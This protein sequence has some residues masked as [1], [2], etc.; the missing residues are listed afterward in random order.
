MTSVQVSCR[1]VAMGA[2]LAVSCVASGQSIVVDP[3]MTGAD[4]VVLL[5][6]S[7]QLIGPFLPMSASEV[8]GGGN[9]LVVGNTSNGVLEL[10][11]AGASLQL[12]GGRLWVGREA[13]SDGTLRL[14]NGATFVKT[15]SL[16]GNI[17]RDGTGRV[18]VW[19]GSSF[20]YSTV[21][22]LGLNSGSTGIVDI[23]ASTF[24]TTGLQIGN[25]GNATFTA[26]NLSTI[27]LSSTTGF[28]VG[29]GDVS[30][31]ETGLVATAI[32]DNST[33]T[34]AGGGVDL[35]VGQRAGI[36]GTLTL[37]NNAMA[38]FDAT[39]GHFIGE[40]SGSNGTL[41]IESGSDLTLG[42][43]LT[44]G[45]AA[46]STGAVTVDGMGS[47]LT[48][49]G[50][51]TSFLGDS[52]TGVLNISN[53]GSASFSQSLNLA[54]TGTMSSGTINI[55][56]AGSMLSTVN[57]L[58][59]GREGTGTLAASAGAFI[60]VGS[61]LN[62]GNTTTG[63]GTG[64]FTGTAV[65]ALNLT[66]GGNGMGI[67]TAQSGTS[68]TIGNVLNIGT[69]T[70]ATGSLTLDGS[71]L[72]A[73]GVAVIGG[74]GD[75]TLT[76]RNG[77]DVAIN[78]LP[79]S[80]VAETGVGSLNIESGSSLDVAGA[81]NV[82]EFAS[83]VGTINIGGTNSELIA[84]DGLNIGNRGMGTLTATDGA[85][86]EL[87]TRLNI[88]GSSTGDGMATMSGTTLIA[89]S[90]LVARTGT[91]E[92]TV[93]NGSTL[94]FGGGFSI[95]RDAGASGTMSITDTTVTTGT[96]GVS[97]GVAGTGT[98]HAA[99]SDITVVGGDLQIGSAN[100]G[101]MSL[102]NG[103]SL[104]ITNTGTSVVG[105]EAN[106]NTP[107]GDGTLTVAGG[108]MG[109]STFTSA[110]SLRVADGG[111]T[112]NV[113]ISGTGSS[114]TL[115]ERLFVGYD[116]DGTMTV[117]D[118]ATLNVN[119]PMDSSNV[120]FN[121]GS[122]ALNITNGGSAHFTPDLYVGRFADG[123]LNADNATISLGRR[124][125]ISDDD[126][127]SGEVTLS[128]SDLTAL[129]DMIVA[130]RGTGTLTMQSGS[131]AT[132]AGG[133]FVGMGANGMGTLA[134][135]ASSVATVNGEAEF[136]GDSTGTGN[137]T[138]DGAGSTLS[139]S[140]QVRF[141][142]DGSSTATIRNG[143][144][145]TSA[146]QITLGDD[147]GSSGDVAIETG[148][149]F[150]TTD[151]LRIGNEG[152][153]T[154]TVSG[155]SVQATDIIIASGLGSGELSIA[156]GGVIADNLT[157]GSGSSTFNF[158]S[159][160]LTL[161]ADQ[162][163]GATLLGF[164]NG[165]NAPAALVV[166]AD[167]AYSLLGT[168]N[169][170]SGTGQIDLNGG[171]LT[172]GDFTRSGSADIDFLSGTLT[173]QSDQTLDGA[174]LADFGLESGVLSDALG[175]QVLRIEGNADLATSLELDGGSLFAQTLSGLE[176]LTATRGNLE[177][178]QLNVT[179]QTEAFT[180]PDSFSNG[181]VS[182]SINAIDVASGSTLQGGASLEAPLNIQDGGTLRLTEGQTL[183]LTNS[184]VSTV[185]NS[186][187]IDLSG[188]PAL[189]GTGLRAELSSDGSITNS[190]GAEIDMGGF[191]SL[192]SGFSSITN[193]GT[194]DIRNAFALV[195]AQGGF[196]NNGLVRVDANSQVTITGDVTNTSLGT[197]S[198]LPGSSYVVIDN[199]FVN[200]G[201]VVD[202]GAGSTV[203]LFDGA[204]GTNLSFTGG[205]TVVFFG[206][207]LNPR[208]DDGEARSAGTSGFDVS[209]GGDVRFGV[210][211]NTVIELAGTLPGMFDRVHGTADVRLN[212][213]LTVDFADGFRLARNQEFLFFEIDGIREGTYRNLAEGA[214]VGT[215]NGLDVFV[216]YLGGDG[217]DIALYTLP[218]PGTLALG[219]LALPFARRR[220]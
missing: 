91:G 132:I 62:F 163:L 202:I 106:G 35:R 191:S 125:I 36:M 101:I 102:S 100:S 3:G 71:T 214:V 29:A 204:S 95:G 13:G 140:Q 117:T 27:S 24:S 55:G 128:Q 118:G 15:G 142:N 58:A 144:A 196:T 17:G 201:G 87:G 159:G 211:T 190:V 147:P 85:R 199:A 149:T 33:I 66:V 64:T 46:G 80:I 136:G 216:T 124:L 220:R 23:D 74:G 8:I 123:V 141:G 194:I 217:N 213:W 109:G 130:E 218:V 72:T 127:V 157:T 164:L 121:G 22:R 126:A 153:G 188:S 73:A 19:G 77:A 10:D 173:L 54:Q 68:F 186:G 37:R 152:T 215:S 9:G 30:G 5:D 203:A 60:D 39:T 108:A 206:G 198:I 43:G 25:A 56:G 14:L 11:G 151:N 18:D 116:G 176:N 184:L 70:D 165:S 26:S 113:T 174:R 83:A 182:V 143:G 139:V 131:N 75:G 67:V 82:A 81:L 185:A 195:D 154:L 192:R 79:L 120:G 161:N 34:S 69:G 134:I 197:L 111:A 28:I 148:G 171:S 32:I 162:T 47:T 61:T 63:V 175:V 178:G 49:S 6:S 210:L 90:M 96:S 183:G 97:V 94:D 59:V 115:G 160:S 51:V 93:T 193:D 156:G 103:S 53:G 42:G 48:T 138:I 52:G 7:D 168:N 208:R 181:A 212:G 155:G 84:G 1:A 86:I 200:N 107:N 40:E 133:V 146:G 137:L 207:E 45:Q 38:T 119:A 166:D 179:S 16:F 135:N 122:G 12:S 180:F 65:D 31:I 114:M 104:S 76:L 112:G 189:G 177:I 187:R 2:G 110:G 98:F 172:F 21:V 105:G 99:D 129:G 167:R 57:G 145:L 78:G 20:D 4:D 209:F 219:V 150:S 89:D 169:S 205:G 44:T 158:T 50:A 170:L 88:G 92:L 41:N